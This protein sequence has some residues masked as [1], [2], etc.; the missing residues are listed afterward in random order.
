MKRKLLFVVMM[1]VIVLLSCHMV[2]A[3]QGPHKGG[4]S[5]RKPITV[6]RAPKPA[7]VVKKTPPK[8]IIV[9]N[10]KH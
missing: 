6:R 5:P 2:F 3:Q 4:N 9:H 7:F 8:P 10:L 1:A